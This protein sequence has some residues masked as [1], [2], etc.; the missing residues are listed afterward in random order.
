MAKDT[1]MSDGG[2]SHKYQFLKGGLILPMTCTNQGERNL[3]PFS[4]RAE[5]DILL[6][7]ALS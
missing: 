2:N 5:P 3:L 7:K 4:K 6:Q 1:L